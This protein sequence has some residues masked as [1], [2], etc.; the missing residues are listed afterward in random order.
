MPASTE[1]VK[2]NASL[3]I[4]SCLAK[5]PMHGYRIVKELDRMSEGYFN[6]REGTLYPHLHELEKDELIEGSWEKVTGNRERRVYR[7]TSRGKSQLAS[8]REE[9]A[10]F[11]ISLN[12]VVGQAA[13]G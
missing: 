10:S 12:R 3:L 11:Q 7:I 9:W 2:G 6:L 5:E 8:M 1:F 13:G 4:L